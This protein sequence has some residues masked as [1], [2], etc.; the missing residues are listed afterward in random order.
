MVTDKRTKNDFLHFIYDDASVYLDRKYEL[1]KQ[2][3]EGF[4]QNPITWKIKK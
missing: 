3:W 4:A 1:A 2:Y